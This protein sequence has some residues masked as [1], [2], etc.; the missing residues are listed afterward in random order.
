[1]ERLPVVLVALPVLAAAAGLAAQ[2][3]V[4]AARVIAVGAAV[5]TLLIAVVAFAGGPSHSGPVAL[6][7]GLDTGTV[8]VPLTVRS[9]ALV[10]AVALVVAL[11]AAAVQVFSVWYLKDDDRY[12]VFAATVSLFTAAM[13]LVVLSG[14]LVLTLVGWEVMGWCS[15][16][17]IGHWSRREAPRRAAHKAFLVTRVADIGFVV[18]I[19]GL[20]AGARSTGITDVL[21]HWSAPAAPAL[22]RNVLVVLLV[23]GVLGKSAQMPFQDWLPDAMEGPTPA[24]A[25]IHAATMVAAGTT[26]LASIHS[27]LAAATGARWLLAGATGLTMVLA[28]VLAFAQPDLKRLLAWSTVSQVAIMLAALAVTTPNAAVPPEPGPDT[29]LFH[30]FSHAIFKSLL[31]LAIGWLSVLAGGTAARALAGTARTLPGLL[32]A[33]GLVSLAGVPFVVGGLSKEHVVTAAHAGATGATGPTGPAWVVLV[34]VLLAVP[35]TAAYAMRAYLALAARSDA[36]GEAATVPDPGHAQGS[37][38]AWVAATVGSLAA[39]SVLG[40]LVLLTGRFDLHGIDWPW[41]LVT[42]L[43]AAAGAAMVY[44][45]TP[46]GEDPAGVLSARTAALAAHGLGADPAYRLVVAE[47]VQALA[48]LVAFLDSEVI[49]GYVRGAARAASIGGLLGAR[50]HRRERPSV[51]L[52]LVGVGLVTLLAVGVFAWR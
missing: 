52:A 21:E 4:S 42:L 14:D 40:G 22:A 18:G 27:V 28:G 16:L 8:N 15:Y 13:L 7:P 30:L 44:A 5:L 29:A 49:D 9:G 2:R 50:G 31:F 36:D 41:L 3:R 10:S 1:M 20:S 51:G 6:L 35:L 23:L 46:R 11:V 33:L 38:P 24:S 19:V 45:A 47:P 26:V 17:L 34:A 37:A 43:L 48:R 39:L 12:A 32:F 25:L